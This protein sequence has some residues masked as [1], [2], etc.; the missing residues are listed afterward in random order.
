MALAGVPKPKSRGEVRL[1]SADPADRPVI[2]HRM[3]GDPDDVATLVAGMKALQRIFA[4]RPLA[5]HVVSRLTPD[6][7]PQTD[8]EWEQE[9]RNHCSPSYRPVGTCRMGADDEAVVDPRLKVRGVA[10]LRVAD[11]SIMPVIP[12]AG[13]TAP[14]IMVGEKASAMILEDARS[15][16]PAAS[17]AVMA[18]A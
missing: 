6:P 7:L 9:V 10:G 16:A 5:D 18:I 12:D 15:L 1:R 8:A 14:S 4:T 2:D 3:L 13:M 17:D 11:A